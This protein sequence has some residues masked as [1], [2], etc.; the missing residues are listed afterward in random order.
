MTERITGLGI[1]QGLCS[2]GGSCAGSYDMKSL[3]K[4][5]EHW[6]FLEN[7]YKKMKDDEPAAM[8]RMQE[9]RRQANEAAK[10]AVAGM[11]TTGESQGFFSGVSMVDVDL[12]S[13]KNEL[14]C[15][16]QGRKLGCSWNPAGR[17]RCVEVE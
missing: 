11:P 4:R 2:L 7:H 15:R 16:L 3:A 17:G 9:L 12:C 8:A 1:L 14:Q 6:Q 5:M 10:S 13:R